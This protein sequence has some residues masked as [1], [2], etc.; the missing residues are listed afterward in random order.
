MGLR[1]ALE[2]ALLSEPFDAAEALRLGL[3]NRVVPAAALDA[4]IEALAQR[5]A[6]GPTLAYGRM[7]RLMRRSFDSDLASQLDAEKDAFAGS[8]ATNDFAEGMQAFFDKR[9]ARFQGS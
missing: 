5:L 9:P 2:I 7:R 1:K 4:E 3:V 8:A 6:A